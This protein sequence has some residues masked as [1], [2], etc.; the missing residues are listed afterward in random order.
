MTAFAAFTVLGLVTGAGYAIA[1]SGLVLT[2]STSR[3]FNVGHGAVAMV[4]AFLYWELRVGVGLPVALAI[5]LVVGVAA[6]LFGALV[7]RV[8]MSRL[9]G[10]PVSTTLVVTVGLLVTLIGAAQAIW[11]V[12]ARPVEPFFGQ[13]GISLG[14]AFVTFHDLVT[15]AT[16]IVVAGGL[17][18]LLSFTRTGTAM[19]ASVDNRA[20]IELFGARPSLLS[21]L[22]WAIGSALAALAGILLTPVVGLSYFDLT[23]LVISAYAAAVA[24]RLSSLPRTFVGAIL[25]G[26][27]QS[28]AVGYL[29]AQA[30]LT[31]LRA[32]IPALF[33]FAALLLSPQA[34][35]RVGQV[36]GIAGV[37][38]PTAGR[39]TVAAVAMVGAFAVA[40]FALPIVQV[41]RLALGLI[42]GIVMLSL[43]PLTGY[44]GFVSLTQLTFVGIGAVVVARIGSPSPLALLAGAAVAAAV[45]VLVALPALRLQGLYL[46]LSTLAFGLLMDKVVFQ[47]EFAFGFN[48]SL[49]VPRLTLWGIDLRTSQ[50]YLVGSA[51]AFA[52]VGLGVLALR[53]SR[54]GR[55]L[56]ALRDSPAACATLGLNTRWTRVRL[57]ALSAGIAGFAGGL[58]GGLRQTVGA[59]DFQLFNSLPLLLLAVVAGVSSVTGAAIG[60]MLLMLAPVVASEF[61]M[62]G[63]LVFL[64]VGVAAVGLGRDPNGLANRLFALGR[65]RPRQPAPVP[66]VRQGARP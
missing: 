27:A 59:T 7:D 25:L 37:R 30:W 8:V 33:L 2:Y 19:R 50:A 34:Q 6:P 54:H 55:I 47:A 62:L 58:F 53:R 14:S 45:G 52:G 63:G 12:A 35:L 56:L 51:V 18:G 60:G 64:V 11:P 43:V 16:A 38:V 20:L 26:L 4:M 57:F 41:D 10:A 1:A 17:W 15:I 3:I 44:G 29:P 39:S 46:A 48:G 42:Y 49:D 23:L 31:G 9:A 5:L 13:R 61:P 21:S 40:S 28:Y 32:A 66:M 24:G 65:W 36:K 22:S